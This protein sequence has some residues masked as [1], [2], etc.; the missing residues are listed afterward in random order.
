MHHPLLI[1]FGCEATRFDNGFWIRTMP[2]LIRYDDKVEINDY[3][4]E[5]FDFSLLQ[6][7]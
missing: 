3:Y 4:M 1:G 2:D 6:R 5:I 7:T